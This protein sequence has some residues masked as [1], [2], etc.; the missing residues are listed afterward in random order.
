MNATMSRDVTRADI[1]AEYERARRALKSELPGLTQD[2]AASR[3]GQL[4]ATLDQGVARI[5]GE[6]LATSLCWN[7]DH[8]ALV[9]WLCAEHE[10]LFSMAHGLAQARPAACD[11]EVLTLRVPAAALYHWGEAVKWSTRRERQDYQPLHAV[12]SAALRHGSQR[13]PVRMVADGR[14]R[15]VTLE[16][17]YFRALLLD[18]FAGGS[19]TR[20]QLEIL[21]A[22][23][24]EWVPALNARREAPDARC[25]R[26]DLDSNT[27][28]REGAA[29]EGANA[30]YLPL[31]PL[32][33][34][35]RDVIA[36]LHQG[37]LVPEHGCASEMRLEE[38]VAVL[39]QV[40]RAFEAAASGREFRAERR[41]GAGLRIEVWVGIQEIL[42]RG[43]AP[44]RTDGA[45]KVGEEVLAAIAASN[46]MNS[47]FMLADD[48]SR[49][50]LWLTDVSES[51]FGFEALGSDAIGIAV[52][53]LLGWRKAP[54]E[55]CAIGR[56]ARRMPGS[57]SN[58]VYFGVQLLTAAARA[59]KLVEIA[60]ERELAEE[61]HI[62]VPGDDDSG[63]RDA[64][65][66]TESRHR[67]ST[68]YRARIEDHAFHLKLDRLRQR[69]RG[70][71]LCGFEVEALTV[72]APPV[73][74]DAVELPHFR[75]PGEGDDDGGLEHALSREVSS[76]LLV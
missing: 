51:G 56:V 7:E 22:W 15:T 28:L 55:P 66:V 59:V 37:R 50:Y 33:G 69:G 62:Y 49:R 11:D 3:L 25:F 21:D 45:T 16:A 43:L 24:W 30:L 40:G 38:H 67:E 32:I 10:H 19:L 4:A 1:R 46:P 48:P 18:R 61:M 54:G 64:F 9:G 31:Q 42:S 29:A 13:Q 39:E 6:L 63:R 20:P 70:W 27:G 47:S 17:L 57:S 14:G 75:L 60:G 72:A 58:Q 8:Q 52:G 34:R 74:Q 36:H 41:P 12:M 65:L 44:R 26:A 53:D 23:L 73:L 2:E 68:V 5:K 71:V 35:R 76:R